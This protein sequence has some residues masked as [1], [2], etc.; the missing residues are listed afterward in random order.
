L[1]HRVCRHKPHDLTLTENWNQF[2]F[3]NALDLTPLMRGSRGRP[4]TARPVHHL[5]T[6]VCIIWRITNS[7]I[8]PSATSTTTAIAQL[9]QK[10]PVLISRIR[11]SSSFYSLNST[12]LR[13]RSTNCHWQCG[14][15]LPDRASPQAYRAD[16]PWDKGCAA[17]LAL[18]AVPQEN[19]CVGS[20]GAVWAASAASAAA[21]RCL[22]A[23]C[24]RQCRSRL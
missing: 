10:L 16:A 22:R 17:N 5:V 20:E 3:S 24:S 7:V 19:P 11:S 4:G 14:R 13:R 1:P 23:S 18:R 2:C 8:S 9:S 21:S 6:G 15:A 12:L